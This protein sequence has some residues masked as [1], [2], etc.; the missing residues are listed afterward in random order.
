MPNM[1]E[2]ICEQINDL[3]KE[4]EITVV[5]EVELK[6]VISLGFDLGECITPDRLIQVLK[7]NLVV[8]L[9]DI[10]LEQFVDGLVPTELLD[11]S[12]E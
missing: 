7:E 12:A 8:R 5:I 2:S 11:W 10:G 1:A 3:T 4:Q 9:G 6:Q